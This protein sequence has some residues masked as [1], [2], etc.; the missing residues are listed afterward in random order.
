MNPQT[1]A[2]GSSEGWSLYRLHL[3]VAERQ[4]LPEAL[5]ECAM[6]TYRP[7]EGWGLPAKDATHGPRVDES[8]DLGQVWRYEA[9]GLAVLVAIYPN[10]SRSAWALLDEDGDT[11]TDGKRTYPIT[12]RECAQIIH[13][14]LIWRRVTAADLHRSIP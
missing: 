3:T 14:E 12:C 8:G 9:H 10:G 6:G 1:L 5:H 13:D 7:A 4:N 2:I 11:I